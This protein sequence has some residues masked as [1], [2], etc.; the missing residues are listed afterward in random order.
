MRG[1][2]RFGFWQNAP[3]D[4]DNR[5]GGQDQHIRLIGSVF[6]NIKSFF[7]SKPRGELCGQFSV[8]RGFVNIG[9]NNRVGH[10]A[11]LRQQCLTAR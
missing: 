10:N 7:K 2:A 3:P 1:I 9:R 8:L 5:I 11:D 6:R 4:T